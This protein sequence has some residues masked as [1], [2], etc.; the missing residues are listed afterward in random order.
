MCPSRSGLC[1]RCGSTCL[2]RLHPVESKGLKIEFI[3]ERIDRPDWIIF[4]DVVVEPLGLVSVLTFDE[5]LH[6]CVHVE[7][8]AVFYQ[9]NA[10]FSHTLGR[11]GSM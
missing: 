9:E 11:K 8:V 7:C 6:D 5:S 4:T 1:F 3:D 2:L 10:A